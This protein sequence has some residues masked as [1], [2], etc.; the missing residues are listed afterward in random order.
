MKNYK[1]QEVMTIYNFTYLY[2][3]IFFKIIKNFILCLKYK[4]TNFIYKN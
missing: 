2:I 3:I 1:K 4:F